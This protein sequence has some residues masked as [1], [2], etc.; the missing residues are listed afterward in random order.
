MFEMVEIPEVEAVL[1]L[2]AK[3]FTLE[4]WEIMEFAKSMAEDPK[5]PPRDKQRA[6]GVYY[7]LAKELGLPNKLNEI[8]F[9]LDYESRDAIEKFKRSEL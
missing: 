5:S 6:Y 8:G 2:M 4:D 9:R 7:I 3:S 1:I